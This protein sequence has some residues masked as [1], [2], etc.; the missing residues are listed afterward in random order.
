ASVQGASLV[1]YFT[2]RE[3]QTAVSYAETLYPK[4][5]MGW[6]ELRA[7]RTNHWKYVRAPKPELYDLSQ[8]PSEKAN[9][10]QSHSVEVQKFEAQLRAVIGG[11]GT[12]KVE[13]SLIDAH[14]MDQL[15][16]LGYVSGFS[17]STYSLTGQGADPKDRVGIL[18]LLAFAEDPDAHTPDS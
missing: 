5:N 13:T 8:D 11:D 3:A 18:K 7:I 17:A 2:G 14:T 1:P 15:K 9:L 12:E 10:I 4:I 16:S 6:A